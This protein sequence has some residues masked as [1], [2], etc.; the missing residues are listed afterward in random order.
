[1]I[2][3]YNKNILDWNELP[4]HDIVW[5]DPPWEERMTK[6][7][8]TKMKKDTGKDVTFDF[9]SIINKLANLC[10]INK[11]LYIEYDIKYY[12]KIITLFESKGHKFV[13]KTTHMQVTKYPFVILTFNTKIKP[14]EG[15]T[16]NDAIVNTLNQYP[17]TQIIFDPFAGIGSTAKDVQKTKHI[18]IGS[19]IN[20]MR[21][22]KLKTI[23][24][25]RAH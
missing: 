5:T 7:F 4:Q 12:H 8:R 1:M 22:N 20:T 15:G 21:F 25:E 24:I 23:V 3:T 18:Y 19:E 16:G 2:T 9:N 11:P 13:S 10:N 6:W 14:S 17:D